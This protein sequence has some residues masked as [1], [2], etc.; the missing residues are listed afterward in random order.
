M[1]RC[2]MSPIDG[3]APSWQYTGPTFQVNS[4]NSVSQLYF[5]CITMTLL[6]RPRRALQSTIHWTQQRIQALR[7]HPAWRL[8]GSKAAISDMKCCAHIYNILVCT[9]CT[10]SHPNLF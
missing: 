2:T 6:L 8:S 5:D 7:L 4:E 10:A 9:T 3:L 1:T